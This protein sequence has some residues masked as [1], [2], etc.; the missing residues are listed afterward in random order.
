[1]THTEAYALA[2]R[3]YRHLCPQF[4]VHDDGVR[5]SYPL[6]AVMMRET[7]PI[8]DR[9]SAQS[10]I[11]RLT[12]DIIPVLFSQRDGQLTVPLRQAHW[13]CQ[14]AI[15]IEKGNALPCDYGYSA[16]KDLSEALQVPIHE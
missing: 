10:A 3:A 16:Y 2:D 14:A 4:L 9:V 1:M 5:P 8:H 12:K 15:E 6:L 7:W 13:L 11:D